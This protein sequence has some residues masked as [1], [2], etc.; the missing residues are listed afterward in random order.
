MDGEMFV[1]EAP[2]RNIFGGDCWTY[3][4]YESGTATPKRNMTSITLKKNTLFFIKS[5]Y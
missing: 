3:L 4:P 2:A 5:I 1:V